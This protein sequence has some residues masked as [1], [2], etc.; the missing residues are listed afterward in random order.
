YCDFHPPVPLIGDPSGGIFYVD[1]V[2]QTEFDPSTAGDGTHLVVYQFS[3]AYGCSTYDSS[4]ILVDDCLGLNYLWDEYGVSIFPN[5]ADDNLS[6]LLRDTNSSISE[7]SIRNETG[8][9]LFKEGTI[10]FANNSNY[11]KINISQ[12]ADGIYFVRLTKGTT[13]LV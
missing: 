12:Y 3:N 6:I 1:G 10:A 13:T 11:F 4:S 7:I 8:Q 5:P 2:E 9:L